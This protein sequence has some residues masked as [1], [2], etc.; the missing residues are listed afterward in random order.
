M[1]HPTPKPV[2]QSGYFTPATSIAMA[3]DGWFSRKL[4]VKESISVMLPARFLD[5]R[6]L[7][8]VCTLCAVEQIHSLL[9]LRISS[10][11]VAAVCKG[12]R[13]FD[14]CSL[15]E[16]SHSCAVPEGELRIALTRR[17]ERLAGNACVRR[18]LRPLWS[19]H[20]YSMMNHQHSSDYI[21][22]EHE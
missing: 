12:F 16:H 15:S 2:A 3:V 4:P 1:I 18:M 17:P 6:L 7:I 22:E 5:R 8:T 20:S 10:V 21:V 19:R 13:V 11:E 9:F 14:S